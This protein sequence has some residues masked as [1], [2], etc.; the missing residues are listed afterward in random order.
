MLQR[1]RLQESQVRYKVTV[2]KEF[3]IDIYRDRLLKKK[4]KK[5]KTFVLTFKKMKFTDLWQY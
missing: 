4:K 1:K 2:N 5:H 3:C